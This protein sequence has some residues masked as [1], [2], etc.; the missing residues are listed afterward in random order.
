MKAG[1]ALVLC[2]CCKDLVRMLSR[3]R[4]CMQLFWRMKAEGHMR[5]CAEKRA[6]FGFCTS[7]WACVAAG[8][9]RRIFVPA[10]R[11]FGKQA[12]VID[13]LVSLSK[14]GPSHDA[15]DNMA[16]SGCAIVPESKS[17]TPRVRCG[18]RN[19]GERFACAHGIILT[20]NMLRT[21]AGRCPAA[22]G[23]CARQRG[24]H[25]GRCRCRRLDEA[26]LLSCP[27]HTT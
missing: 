19:S 12:R 4:W 13:V 10:S 18:S 9:K 21:A 15:A 26:V 14:H 25:S 23:A 22:H 17:D 3:C 24:R 1:M 27:S 5:A 6:R 16:C 11:G 20:G 8:G 7:L 2:F